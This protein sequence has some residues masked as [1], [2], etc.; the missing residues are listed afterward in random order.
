MLDSTH[1]VGG[2]VD[3]SGFYVVCAATELLLFCVAERF[4][5]LG[6]GMPVSLAK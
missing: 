5:F 3:R 6:W 2:Y 1:G 4:R